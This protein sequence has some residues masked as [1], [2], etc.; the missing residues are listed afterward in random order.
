MTVT[1]REDGTGREVAY[2]LGV[3]GWLRAPFP[4]AGPGDVEVEVDADDERLTAYGPDGSGNHWLL[5]AG[6]PQD[7]VVGG[8]VY[9]DLSGSPALREVTTA[10]WRDALAAAPGPAA[11]VAAAAATLFS[12]PLVS[13]P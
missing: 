12:P 6:G 11:A 4:A 8:A 9:V 1:A 10:A 2:Q 3:P 13:G 5:V 7:V